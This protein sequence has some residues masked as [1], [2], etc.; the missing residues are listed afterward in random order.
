LRSSPAALQ[1]QLALLTATVK[2]F[3]KRPVAGQELLPRVLKMATEE[4]DNP[5]LRDRVRLPRGRYRL[6]SL[7]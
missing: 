3:I 2:L 1:V 6:L 4:A 5:D 7:L